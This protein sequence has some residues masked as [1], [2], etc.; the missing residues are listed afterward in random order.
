MT[1]INADNHAINANQSVSFHSPVQPKKRRKGNEVSQEGREY[2]ENRVTFIALSDSNSPLSTS[3]STSPNTSPSTSPRI[4][5]NTSP[6]TS[7]ST[8]PNS[9]PRTPPSIFRSPELPQALG[10][11][12]RR[13]PPKTPRPPKAPRKRP[14]SASPY[15]EGA[16]RVANLVDSRS[17]FPFI[18]TIGRQ[19]IEVHNFVGTLG[20][21]DYCDVYLIEAKYL[22]GE[23]IGKIALKVMNTD[24]RNNDKTL[25]KIIKDEFEQYFELKKR[26][27]T[28]GDI[29]IAAHLDLDIALE[30]WG[31]DVEHAPYMGHGCHLVEYIPHPYPLVKTVKE[32]PFAGCRE[33]AFD[34]KLK[35]LFKIAFEHKDQPFDLKWDN[36]RI[37][38][39]DNL[40]VIDPMYPDPD[41][42]NDNY[43]EMMVQSALES[44]APKDSERYKFLDPR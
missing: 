34:E 22:T 26:L 14:A 24:W 31:S 10:T 30:E 19:N 23:A 7:S 37:D 42:E 43:F 13:Q 35:Q 20:K 44:F 36:V 32:L 40:V 16:E 5:P 41:D 4:S 21:G 8:P 18:I 12:I 15:G 17:F 2:L 6:K 9:P 27:G 29:R 28:S 1:S 38:D 25:S 3:P 39:H 11:L 33:R